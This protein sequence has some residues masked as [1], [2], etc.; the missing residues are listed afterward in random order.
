MQRLQRWKSANPHTR[1]ALRRLGIAGGALAA[2]AL[3]FASWPAA[4]AQ[5]AGGRAQPL[6]T[7]A[8][9]DGNLVSLAGNTRPEARN[10]ANDRGRVDDAMPMPHLMLQL[11]RPAAQE[12]A[13]ADADRSAARPA[14]AELS[15]LAHRKRNRRAIRACGIG[16]REHHRLARAARLHRQFGLSKR[17]GDRFF[18]HGGP[19]PRRLPHR[20]P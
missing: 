9:N 17:D 7:Q 19:G 15:P 16:R 20:D 5:T 12:Q 6:I 11:R 13:F 10:P 8:V 1:R 14:V 18:R 3:G 2:V 4:L